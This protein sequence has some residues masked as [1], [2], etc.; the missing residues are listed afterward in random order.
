MEPFFEPLPER[1][2]QTANPV[3]PCHL[4]K[5]RITRRGGRL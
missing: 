4:V 5:S 1:D 3:N 2:E